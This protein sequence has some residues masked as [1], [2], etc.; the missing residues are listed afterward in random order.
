MIQQDFVFTFV[1]SIL[2]EDNITP[3]VQS[4]STDQR[5]PS[6]ATQISQISTKPSFKGRHGNS[7]SDEDEDEDTE[8]RL[9]SCSDEDPN[10]M[11][12]KDIDYSVL[13]D[14]SVEDFSFTSAREQAKKRILRNQREVMLQQIDKQE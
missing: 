6:F 7:S 10:D 12:G 5:R 2:L 11:S 3:V 8:R 9:S 13:F 4:S 1:F 14:E